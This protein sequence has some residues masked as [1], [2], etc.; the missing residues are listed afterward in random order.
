MLKTYSPPRP[1]ILSAEHGQRLV[2][3]TGSFIIRATRPVPESNTNT[4]GIGVG[5]ECQIQRS[6]QPQS[7]LLSTL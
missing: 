2:H 5:G 6:S 7:F 3:T 1:S 4:P